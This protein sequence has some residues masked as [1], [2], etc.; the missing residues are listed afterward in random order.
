MNNLYWKREKP[1]DYVTITKCKMLEA[2]KLM[3]A[4]KLRCCGVSAVAEYSSFVF[5]SDEF[6]MREVA[7]RIHV[8]MNIGFTVP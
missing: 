6:V 7:R 1:A 3:S 5:T 8:E 4:H 2:I